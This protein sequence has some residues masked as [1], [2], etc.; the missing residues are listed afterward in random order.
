M[1]DEYDRIFGRIAQL[2]LCD[3]EFAQ[4]VFMWMTYALR[5][6][7]IQEIQTAYRIDWERYTLRDRILLKANLPRICGDL[8]VYEEKKWQLSPTVRFIHASVQD[9]IRRKWVPAETTRSRA[10]RINTFLT[11]IEAHT[12]MA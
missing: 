11:E 12:V 5:P 4:H 1:S 6:L 7:T 3:Q 2:E 9:Y 8:V 10:P